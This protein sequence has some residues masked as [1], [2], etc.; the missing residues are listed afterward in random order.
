MRDTHPG[1]LYEA[2]MIRSKG[3]DAEMQ[4]D[5]VREKLGSVVFWKCPDTPFR[6]ID[7]YAI[8]VVVIWFYAYRGLIRKSGGRFILVY[9]LLLLCISF[10]LAFFAC[11][12]FGILSR[13]PQGVLRDD[14]HIVE[15]F[16]EIV[17]DLN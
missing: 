16:D 4:N 11:C 1:K 13:Q 10:I 14:D 8:L 5:E 17:P 7:L 3:S 12:G 15:V 6:R 2:R 9:F